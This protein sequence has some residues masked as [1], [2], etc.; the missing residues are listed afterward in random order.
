M[1]KK[2]INKFLKLENMYYISTYAT[3]T[4]KKKMEG[5]SQ[6]FNQQEYSLNY[7]SFH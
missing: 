7:L 4:R 1:G 2:N 3:W 6:S 5:K